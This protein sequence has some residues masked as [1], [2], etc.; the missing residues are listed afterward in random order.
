MPAHAAAM[1]H[2]TPSAGPRP[3][4]YSP[5]PVT[6]NAMGTRNAGN[7]YR[8]VCHIVGIARPPVTAD[9]PTAASA[10]GGVISDSTE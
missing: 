4:R 7:P 8:R 1:T 10:V 3:S 9:A 5:G 2:S 6:T